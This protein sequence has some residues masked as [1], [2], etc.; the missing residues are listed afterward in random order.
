MCRNCSDL[1]FSA[2]I[3]GKYLIM[4]YTAHLQEVALNRSAL[5]SIA[6]E[7]LNRK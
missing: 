4:I 6:I 7:Q 2:D 3:A 5:H 1:V